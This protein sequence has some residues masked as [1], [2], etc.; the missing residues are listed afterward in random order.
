M[1][2]DF[3]AQVGVMALTF[4]LALTPAL[5]S[6]RMERSDYLTLMVIPPAMFVIAVLPGIVVW[7]FTKDA[8]TYVLGMVMVLVIATVNY[9][10]PPRSRQ[11]AVTG[12][13]SAG[14]IT[15]TLEA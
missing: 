14:A 9:R 7:G 6:R 3:W 5:A 1:T 10:Y 8:A 2:S 4:G 13:A 15:T 12:A 11:K